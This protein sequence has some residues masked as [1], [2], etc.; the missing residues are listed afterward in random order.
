M[1]LNL[2]IWREIISYLVYPWDKT[3]LHSL[4]VTSRCLSNLALDTIW[5]RDATVE[6]IISLIN[7]LTTPNEPFLEYIQE[8]KCYAGESGDEGSPIPSSEMIGNWVSFS[9]FSLIR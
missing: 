3:T 1:L 7:S 2:D 4:A 9:R 8:P 6:A 5:R